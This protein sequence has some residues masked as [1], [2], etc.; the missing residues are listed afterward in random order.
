MRVFSP[1]AAFVLSCSS[2]SCQPCR[3]LLLSRLSEQLHLYC[4]QAGYFLRRLWIEGQIPHRGNS[5]A[6]R[7]PEF[8][9]QLALIQENSRQ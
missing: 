1:A 6:A 3:T 9:S 7:A 4:L 5:T 2:R 8:N